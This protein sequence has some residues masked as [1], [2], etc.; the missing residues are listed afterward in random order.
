MYDEP[1]SLY[2]A[3]FDEMLNGAAETSTTAQ[4]LLYII[5]ALFH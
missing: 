1:I 5:T 3:S 2:L 4:S